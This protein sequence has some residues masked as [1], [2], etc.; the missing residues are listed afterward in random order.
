MNR[1]ADRGHQVYVK[2]LDNEVSAE[3]KQSIVDDWG[4][5]YQLI[6]QTV[7]QRNISERAIR[8]FKAHFYHFWME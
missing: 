2:I 5:T 7:H 3:F 4:A 8:N 1:L 6:P